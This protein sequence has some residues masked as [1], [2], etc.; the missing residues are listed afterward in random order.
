MGAGARRRMSLSR[1]TDDYE[2]CRL[3]PRS[4]E[5]RRSH[6]GVGFCA[7]TDEMRIAWA[8]IHCG[9]EPPISGG[10]GSGTVFFSGCTL[11]CRFCQNYQI[12]NGV[13]GYAVTEAELAGIFLDLKQAG[14][15]NINL[16]T[17]TQFAPGIVMALS[18]CGFEQLGVPVVWNSSGFETLETLALLSPAV[19]VY[20]ADMKTLNE[21]LSHEIFRFRHYPAYAQAAIEAMVADKQLTFK[22]DLLQRGVVVRH[23]VLPGKLDCT[24][25]VIRWFAT[26]L[27]GRALLSAMFQ[28]TPVLRFE[29]LDHS[30]SRHV[31]EH[32]YEQVLFWLDEYGIEDGYVQDITA[33]ADWLPDFTKL[34]PFPAGAARTVWS[35]V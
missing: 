19:D 28:Y 2:P 14:A 35:G 29:Q 15:E 22:G 23:L 9:E 5:V 8:G 21:T 3:C 34:N 16:V 10:G 33:D 30:F 12:S 32:E 7:Q 17:G 20:L 24:H 18:R 31:D 4:C 26:K 27:S 13:V 11:G 25:A 1:R 6:D